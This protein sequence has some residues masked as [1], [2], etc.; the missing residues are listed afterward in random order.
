MSFS[1]VVNNLSNSELSYDLIRAVNNNSEF[2][3][4]IFFQNNLPPIIQP[5]CLTMNLTGLSGLTGATVSFDLECA[6]VVDAANINTKNYLYLYDLEWLYKPINYV[7]ARDLMSR[8]TIFAR[9]ETHANVISNFI[10]KEVKIVYSIE[11]L[12][13]CLTQ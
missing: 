11:E 9:S 8:F 3:N 12:F 4:N 2:S 6:S 7:Q 10:D 5:E 13:K 1:F